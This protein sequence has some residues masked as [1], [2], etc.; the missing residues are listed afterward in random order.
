MHF[1]LRNGLSKSEELFCLIP[2]NT[3]N[4]I[5][6]VTLCV[7][8]GY[9][10]IKMGPVVPRVAVVVAVVSLRV[11]PTAAAAGLQ[12]GAPTPTPGSRG[13]RSEEGG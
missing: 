4:Y 10:M 5:S 2:L 7:T 12:P 6:G 13:R 3:A 8:C 1:K 11:S 9:L